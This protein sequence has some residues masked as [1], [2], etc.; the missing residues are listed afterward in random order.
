MVQYKSIKIINNIPG[1]VKVII[2]KVMY[3]HR[4]TDSIITNQGFIFTSK[5]WSSLCYFLGIKRWLS[6]FLYLQTNGQTK[7]QNNIMKGYLQAFII[8]EQNDWAKLLSMAKFASNNTKN[9]NT[10]HMLFKLNCNYHP[11]VSFQENTNFC[12]RSKTVDKLSTELQELITVCQVNLYLTEKLQKQ[13]HNKGIKLRSYAPS[14]KVWINNK[15]IKTKQD[16]KL[17]TKFF[18]P[19]GVLYLVGKQAHKLKLLKRERIQ[20]VFHVSLLKQDITRKGRIDKKVTE[21]KFE[22]GNNKIK[23]WL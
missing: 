17:E 8:F 18:R 16:Q 7:K 14:D 1:L 5:F 13:T 23:K 21:L 20:D 9:T 15:Y 2:N 3:Y 6:T 10:S 12:F 11:C 22:I 19:F 4:I